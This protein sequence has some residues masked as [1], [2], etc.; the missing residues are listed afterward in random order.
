M[1]N[2]ANEISGQRLVEYR[3][4]DRPNG[5]FQLVDARARRHPARFDVQSCDAVIIAVKKRQEVLGKV[6]LVFRT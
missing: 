5:R 1:S 3:L 6:T 4:A 2:C